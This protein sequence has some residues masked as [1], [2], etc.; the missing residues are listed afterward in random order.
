MMKLANLL[1]LKRLQTQEPLFSLCINK[2][3]EFSLFF[4]LALEVLVSIEDENHPLVEPNL[5]LMQIQ[6]LTL[7]R[8]RRPN[9]DERKKHD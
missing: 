2:V 1:Q 6:S 5:S 3:N 8:L 9:E 4:R 7:S